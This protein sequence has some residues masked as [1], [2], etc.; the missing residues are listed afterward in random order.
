MSIEQGYI[1]LAILALLWAGMIIGLSFIATPVKFRAKSL[2]RKAA[3]DVGR[4]TFRLFSRVE[5]VLA[6]LMLI[7]AWLAKPEGTLTLLIGLIL[8]VIIV[9]GAW[10]TPYLVRR[11]AA[12]IEGHEPPKSQAHM[13]FV[14]AE[15]LKLLALVA[16]GATLLLGVSQ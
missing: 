9:Q 4:V 6:V 5:M 1:A 14:S 11:A 15:V 3:F 13:L 10:L 2:E 16:L 12:V 8:L 7:V